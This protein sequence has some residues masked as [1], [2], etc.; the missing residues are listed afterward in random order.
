M[1]FHGHIITH[2]PYYIKVVDR[3][4][5]EMA[6]AQCNGRCISLMPTYE[7]K[8]VHK[9]CTTLRLFIVTTKL[10]YA[11]MRKYKKG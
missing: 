6:N 9:L 4:R 10:N 1:Y 7:Q 3:C 2:I 8:T 11:L 5:C